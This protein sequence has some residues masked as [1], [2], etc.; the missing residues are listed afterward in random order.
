MLVAGEG[1]HTFHQVTYLVLR[2]SCLNL[3]IKAIYTEKIFH[4]LGKHPEQWSRKEVFLSIKMKEFY[5]M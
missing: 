3:N 5:A 1:F 2:A 4:L